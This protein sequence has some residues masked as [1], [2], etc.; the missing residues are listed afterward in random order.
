MNII[1]VHTKRGIEYAQYLQQYLSSQA[2][3][4][5]YISDIPSLEELI[6]KN[7]LSSHN[8]LIHSRT[9]G[10]NANKKLAAIEQRGFTIVNS[11]N[12]LTLTSNKYL[13][14]EHA[15]KNNLPVMLT[16]KIKKTDI[17][18]IQNL[19][20]QYKKLVLKPIISQ[21][22][23]IYCHKIE[24]NI[25]QK[26]L[27]E[28]LAMIPEEEIQVQQ[29]IDYKKLLRVI[30]INFKALK[31]ATTYDAP[32]EG[33]WKCSVCLNSNIKKYSNTQDETL[34]TLAEN[35]AKAFDARINFIDFFE[36]QEGKFVLNEINTACN[37]FIHEKIT[38]VSIYKCIGDFLLEEY[39]RL[40]LT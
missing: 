21:G 7:N 28:I 25:S 12:T 2:K 8:T 13:S 32:K 33:D 18:T 20:F 22:Q 31:E 26:A 11:V 35:T 17:N 34:F 36:D 4:T 14:F 23:G 9:A 39:K 1:I 15:Q 27:N 30:V 19:L 6:K 24:K 29:Y 16:Y 5:C 38:N 40:G 10:P 37:L 3:V